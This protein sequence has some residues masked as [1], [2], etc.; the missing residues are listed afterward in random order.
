MDWQK[1]RGRSL[2]R[3]VRQEII[4]DYLSGRKSSYALGVEHG[5]GQKSVQKM[6]SRYKQNNI[7]TFEDQLTI[8]IM[9]RKKKV[10]KDED[11]LKQENEQLKRQLKT[12]MLKLEG[13]QIMG[14]I[15]H[16]EYGIDLLKKSAA[17][18]SSVLKN[19]TQK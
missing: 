15:L 7:N 19:D 2:P 10:S 1:R 18:Q 12:A 9:G 5:I 3:F 11:S 4:Q 14:D 6:V 17:K 16:E 13:Y 8:P